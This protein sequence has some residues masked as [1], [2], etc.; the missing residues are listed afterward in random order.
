MGGEADRPQRVSSGGEVFRHLGKL[1]QLLS[2]SAALDVVRSADILKACGYSPWLRQAQ[3]TL[4]I[5]V[6]LD[7]HPQPI[8]GNTHVRT[9]NRP[10]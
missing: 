4:E 7:L 8:N 5:N 1:L 9:I 6:A 3:H 10:A 2:G